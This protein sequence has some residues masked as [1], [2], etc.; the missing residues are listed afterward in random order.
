M[1]ADVDNRLLSV[2]SHCEID[3]ANS[4]DDDGDESVIVIVIGVDEEDEAARSC[5]LHNI[6]H[7]DQSAECDALQ[8]NV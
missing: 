4:D 8:R 3:R 7:V 2:I 1:S 5:C 6:R